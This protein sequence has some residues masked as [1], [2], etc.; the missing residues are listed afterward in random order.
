VASSN[1]SN[2]EFISPVIEPPIIKDTQAIHQPEPAQGIDS[3]SLLLLGGCAF[4]VMLLMR[5]N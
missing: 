2:S 4:V 1:R 5:G 3:S